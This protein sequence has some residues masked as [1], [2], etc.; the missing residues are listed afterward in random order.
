MTQALFPNWR[1]L[2]RYSP[3]GPVPHILHESAQFRV[4]V[5]GLEAGQRLP[6]HPEAAA[7]YHVL[8]GAGWMTVNGEPIAI[9]PGATVIVPD[10]AVRGIEA[11]TRLAFL[12]VRVG[13]DAT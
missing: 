12:A 1:D 6:V 10:G 13:S 7:M 5:G 9:G 11:N 8:E 4:V 2:V 3:D